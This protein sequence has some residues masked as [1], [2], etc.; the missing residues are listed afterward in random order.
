MPVNNNLFQK[1][2]NTSLVAQLIWKRQRISRVDIARELDLYRSTVS[3]IISYLLSAG[4]VFEGE[5]MASHVQGGRKAIEIS[6]NRDFGCVFGFDIQPS[7]Y[8]AVLLS[9]D[10]TTLW[11]ETG[12]FGLIPLESMID[13]MVEHA[14]EVHKQFKT[15]ILAMSFSIPGIVDSKSGVV[16]YSEPFKRTEPFDLRSYVKA[17]HNFPV[18][19]E[20]DANCAAWMDIY[21]SQDRTLVNALAVVGDFHEESKKTD[22]IIGI[23]TGFGI[24]IDG[25]VYRGAHNAS[26]EFCSLS[27]QPGNPNQ[28]GLDMDILRRTED[29]SEC[30][31]IWLEDT[32]NSFVP[33]CSVMDFEKILLH[34]NPFKNESWVM[35]VLSRRAK[36]FLGA[37]EKTDTELVFDATDEC[38]SAKGSAIMFLHYLFSVPELDSENGEWMSWDE[39]IDFSK[40]QRV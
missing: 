4:V 33:L 36:P 14:L 17:K 21:S 37:I 34:G 3:N 6:L 11:S 1:N 20:N 2:A 24:I 32:F 22:Q 16:L 10:G 15:P 13:N 31:E 39:L 8:R 38:I 27:W 26:G 12:S 40:S 5:H 9:I 28:S 30:L 25:T 23:G 19:V 35:E 7:H 29:D 18:Y